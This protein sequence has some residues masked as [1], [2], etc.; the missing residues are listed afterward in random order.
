MV[1]KDYTIDKATFMAVTNGIMPG[2]MVWLPS[3]VVSGWVCALIEQDAYRCRSGYAVGGKMQGD[4]LSRVI[5][6]R[7]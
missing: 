4:G 5:E 7:S 3:Q 6:N 2:N 1:V